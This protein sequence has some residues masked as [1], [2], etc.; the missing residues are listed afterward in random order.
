MAEFVEL[1]KILSEEDKEWTAKSLSTYFAS[2][3]EP[4]L[5]QYRQGTISINLCAL[6]RN[7]DIIHTGRDKRL[8]TY[9]HV[10]YSQILRS[11]PPPMPSKYDNL[12]KI[13]PSTTN[14]A[15]EIQSMR[16]KVLT[17]NPLSQSEETLLK[18]I[19]HNNLIEE[20]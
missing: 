17:N 3:H 1:L 11:D 10:S 15:K 20:S 19:I 13:D 12:F 7:G 18:K 8:N 14:V 5:P 9:K 16:Y 6:K 2:I 4:D